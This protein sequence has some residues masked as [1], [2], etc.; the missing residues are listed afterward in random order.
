MNASNV[1]DFPAR[2][3][4]AAVSVGELPRG[5]LSAEM[6]IPKASPIEAM[7]FNL[8]SNA[9]PQFN[10]QGND[11]QFDLYRKPTMPDSDK[12]TDGKIEAVEARTDTKITR[13]EGK[14]DVLTATIVGKIDSL[15]DDVSKSDQYNHDTRWVLIS[16]FVVGVFALAGLL[17][18]I[19]TYGDALFG[20]GMSVRDVV[21]TV[22]KE[23]AGNSKAGHD[24]AAAPLTS[25]NR[26]RSVELALVRASSLL[27]ALARY[28]RASTDRSEAFRSSVFNFEKA[29]SIGLRSGE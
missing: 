1:V 12:L 4:Q 14:I 8:Q 6:A 25:T 3:S 15:K 5:I 23:Q 9:A 13:L 16:T 27:R 24:A 17:I 11:A 2:G 20:R 26:P 7:Q 21:Q 18:A 19:A 28:Q 29:I 10:L 22:I